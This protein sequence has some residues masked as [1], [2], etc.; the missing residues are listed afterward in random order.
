MAHFSDTTQL[1]IGLPVLTSSGESLGTIS[2][3]EGTY[4]VATDGVVFT[5]ITYVPVSAITT[6]EPGGIRLEV[7]SDEIRAAGW[8]QVPDDFHADATVPEV[9]GEDNLEAAARVPGNRITTAAIRDEAT[10]D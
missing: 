2:S 7:T 1:T 9:P 4:V 10:S 5:S 8:D 3:V 6:V